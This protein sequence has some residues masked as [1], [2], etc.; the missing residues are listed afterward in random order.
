MRTTVAVRAGELGATVAP[1]S[2]A[3]LF[4]SFLKLGSFAFG[5]VYAM[6]SFFEKELVDRR[7]WLTGDELTECV[8]LGQMMPGPPIVNTGVL[9][10]HRLRGARG[11]V[12]A[13][14]GQILPG[15]V[16]VLLLGVAYA[17]LRSS[18][19]LRGALRGVGAAVVGLLASVSL[20]MGR[21]VVDGARTGLL[22]AAC[23]A[24]LAFAHANPILLL[25][26]AG[27]AGWLLLGGRR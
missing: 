7:R 3:A 6:I 21:R 15:F 25:A 17:E 22:A 20:S 14:L 19:V 18:P 5:G 24:L 11:A 23:F 8:V 12:A 16:V 10:G 26:G 9:V 4:L 27:V 13:T 2:L 1:P